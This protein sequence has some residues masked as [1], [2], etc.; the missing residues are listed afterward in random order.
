MGVDDIELLLTGDER[1]QTCISLD[2]REEVSAIVCLDARSR[3]E[4]LWVGMNAGD[5][6]RFALFRAIT[7]CCRE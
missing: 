6:E 5:L 7:C 4:R 3:H 2:F 1:R